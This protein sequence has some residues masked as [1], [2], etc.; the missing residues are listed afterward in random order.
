MSNNASSDR[1]EGDGH[2]APITR[3]FGTEIVT[4]RLA[5]GAGDVAV[6][7]APTIIGDCSSASRRSA[8][9][10]PRA[11]G[12]TVLTPILR[13][14]YGQLWATG[15]VFDAERTYSMHRAARRCGRL[16]EDAA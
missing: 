10:R 12:L 6:R 8:S 4:A 15:R 1:R 16:T 7:R 11:A 2:H 3:M 14:P 5:R 13:S 9:L